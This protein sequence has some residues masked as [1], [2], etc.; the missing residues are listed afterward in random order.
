[1]RIIGTRIRSVIQFSVYYIK[2]CTGLDIP[3]CSLPF[4]MMSL[5]VE[6]TPWNRVVLEKL[7]VAQLVKE[8]PTINETRRPSNMSTTVCHFTLLRA[9]LIRSESSYSISLRSI[10]ILSSC[11]C[12][13]LRRDPF[14]WQFLTKTLYAFLFSPMRAT[15]LA[16]VILLDFVSLMF[17]DIMKLQTVRYRI[18]NR[19]R[20]T[21]HTGRQWMAQC[22]YVCM[23][24]CMRGVCVYV[25]V[26]RRCIQKF[27]NWVDNEINICWEATQRVMVAKLT[28]LTHKI[29]L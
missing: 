4:K 12:L 27:P 14:P 25:C 21:K 26:A 23:Y 15:C 16:Y 9:K 29:T 28:R 5:V 2:D 20:I 24:V 1:M 8:Y 19:K 10:L 18:M 11:L 7:T 3:W 22:M 13:R 6:L 17:G